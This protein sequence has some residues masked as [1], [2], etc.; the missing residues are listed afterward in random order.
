MDIEESNEVCD[1]K[2]RE[3]VAAP[4]YRRKSK[5]SDGLGAPNGQ[6]I[7]GGSAAAAA[8]A[9][10]HELQMLNNSVTVT[11]AASPT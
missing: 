10:S 11:A 3:K 1:E 9:G 4:S 7:S 6:V 5:Y 8:A 2:K